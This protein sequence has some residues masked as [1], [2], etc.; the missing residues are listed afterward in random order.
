MTVTGAGRPA[1]SL[2][3]ASTPFPYKRDPDACELCGARVGARRLRRVEV[4]PA[5]KGRLPRVVFVCDR[6]ELDEPA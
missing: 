3:V 4:R 6:H 1:P 2:V 5:A